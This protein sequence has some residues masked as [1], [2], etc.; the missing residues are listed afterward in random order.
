MNFDKEKLADLIK[1][2]L[3]LGEDERE[4]R[5]WLEIFED[6]DSQE[7]KEILANLEKEAAELEKAAGNK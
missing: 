5:L 2:L 4:L 7:Q 3:N 1:R 6:L